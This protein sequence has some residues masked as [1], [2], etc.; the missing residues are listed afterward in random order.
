MILDLMKKNYIVV[1]LLVIREFVVG[2]N[3]PKYFNEIH[4]LELNGDAL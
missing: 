1:K 4:S 3:K 2:E